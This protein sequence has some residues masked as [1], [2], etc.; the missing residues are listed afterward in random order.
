MCFLVVR[1]VGCVRL[2]WNFRFNNKPYPRLRDRI[3]KIHGHHTETM[4]YLYQSLIFSY[5]EKYLIETMVAG[6]PFP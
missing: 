4:E 6:V 5:L 1:M 3:G 2:C